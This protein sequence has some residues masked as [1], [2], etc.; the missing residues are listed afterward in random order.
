MQFGIEMDQF[1]FQD[2]QNIDRGCEKRNFDAMIFTTSVQFGDTQFH[3]DHRS[4]Q[5]NEDRSENG[6]EQFSSNSNGERRSCIE[7]V[8]RKERT[9]R[10]KEHEVDRS[11]K[12]RHAQCHRHCQSNTNI[13]KRNNS[14]IDRGDEDE[15]ENE[16][17]RRGT[18]RWLVPTADNSV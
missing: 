4:K 8:T 3:F 16:R 11:M 17:E 5:K 14:I 9:R 2:V 1:L 12:S 7:E 10:A 18:N 6:D 15:N 13:L